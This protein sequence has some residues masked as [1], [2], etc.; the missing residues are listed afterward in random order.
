[1]SADM[2]T[3]PLSGAQLA[4]R[5][6]A[7]GFR[8]RRYVLTG[9]SVNAA[10]SD[11]GSFAGLPAKYLV[12]GLRGFDASISL[13]TATI[14]LRTAAAGAGTALVSA[15]ALA[16]LTAASKVASLTLAVTD[17][18]QTAATLYVRNVTAQGAAATVSLVLE[19]LDLT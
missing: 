1:M 9:V 7:Q 14:D 17:T 18:Y 3:R 10:A 12:L 11:V 16:A 15:Q 2:G 4:A 19:I 6:Q 5:L 13:T 8:S